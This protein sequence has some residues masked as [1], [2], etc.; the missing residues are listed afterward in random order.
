MSTDLI[1]KNASRDVEASTGSNDQER[2]ISM[3]IYT[4]NSI[5]ELLI[6]T[7]STSVYHSKRKFHIRT[8]YPDLYQKI[9]HTTAF[10]VN[11]TFIEQIHCYVNNLAVRPTCKM[12]SNTTT[13]SRHRTYHTYCSQKCGMLDMK[14]LI[15]V[16]NASQLVSVKAKKVTSS[17]A[18]YGVDN[19]SKS[20]TIKN[21]LSIIRHAYWDNIYQNKQYTLDGLSKQDY[22]K[23]ILKLSEYQYRKYKHLVDPFDMRGPT[24]HLDHIYSR[25]HGFIN[26][27][28][29]NIIADISNLR[30]LSASDNL[31]K[32]K[33]SHKSI[34]E[35]YEDYYSN[36]LSL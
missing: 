18:K 13:F 6:Y 10:I 11:A 25:Y 24:Y 28:P 20:T 3:S 17:L 30:I 16:N 2:I 35:L 22:N 4:F 36:Q 9:V 12:C 7:N 26:D 34:I 29:V 5:D 23:E 31:K 14:S 21:Q 15:G 1:N 27:I 19:V 33:S 32:S 8:N